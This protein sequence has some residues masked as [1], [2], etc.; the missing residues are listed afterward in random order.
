MP[1][2]LPACAY[3]LIVLSPALINDDGTGY[4][5]QDIAIQCPGT[6]CRRIITKETL[7]VAKFARDLVLDPYDP[8]DIA[9]YGNGVDLP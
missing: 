2:L 1:N 9:K 4:L 3:A 8:S 5:Q 6:G 7:G